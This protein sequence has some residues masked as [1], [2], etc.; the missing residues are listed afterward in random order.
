[1]QD[2]AGRLK[3]PYCEAYGVSRLYLATV[4][5]DSCECS[6]CG[7]RWDEEPITGQFRGRGT[8]QSVVDG[9]S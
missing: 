8:R 3:C 4:R 2:G 9:R 5:L 6:E 1:M 7:A